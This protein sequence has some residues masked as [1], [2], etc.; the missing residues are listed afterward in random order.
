MRNALG[1]VEFK[2]GN[3]KKKEDIAL[4]RGYLLVST[5]IMEAISL[6]L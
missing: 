6:A 5:D 3:Y 4:P 1:S 2:T